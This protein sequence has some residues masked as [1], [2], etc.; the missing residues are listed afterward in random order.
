MS[1]GGG[2]ISYSKEIGIW[3]FKGFTQTSPKL[4]L[5]QLALPLKRSF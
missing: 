4:H 1:G 5:L 3:V 2:M